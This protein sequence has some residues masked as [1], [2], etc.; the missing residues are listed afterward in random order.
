VLLCAELLALPILRGPR[1][2]K[3]PLGVCTGRQHG[4][5]RSRQARHGSVMSVRD[6]GVRTYRC[7]CSESISI[8][9]KTRDRHT[10]M[11]R[12]KH[13]HHFSRTNGGTSCVACL[14]RMCSSRNRICRQ[15]AKHSGPFFECERRDTHIQSKGVRD[16]DHEAVWRS[17][18]TLQSS[19]SSSVSRWA[20][21]RDRD[22]TTVFKHRSK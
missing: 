6:I 22:T 17:T 16:F 5:A 11:S 4:F 10:D 21:F 12:Q 1:Q 2:Q 9:V 15:L 8:P 3:G 19:R 18:G 7:F 13:P 14:Q 20:N